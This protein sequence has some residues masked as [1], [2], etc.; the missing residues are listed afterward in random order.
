MPTSPGPHNFL[1]SSVKVVYSD[2]PSF[3]FELK[4][5]SPNPFNSV[6]T[7]PFSISKDGNVNLDIYDLSGS[8]V[9]TL[10]NQ[11]LL[12]AEYSVNL[13]SKFLTSGTYMCMIE[14][15]GLKKSRMIVVS[16]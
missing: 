5:N 14:V 16:K 6:T 8:K 9:L 3:P 1:P 10:V 4:P 11:Y 13:D 2:K 15:N 7:I 12:A